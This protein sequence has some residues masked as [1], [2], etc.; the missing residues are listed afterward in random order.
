MAAAEETTMPQHVLSTEGDVPQL[1]I[2]FRAVRILLEAVATV[3]VDGNDAAVETS[4]E[5]DIVAT[6]STQQPFQQATIAPPSAELSFSEEEAFGDAPMCTSDIV[7]AAVPAEDISSSTGATIASPVS[8]VDSVVSATPATASGEVAPYEADGAPHHSHDKSEAESDI[9]T[10]HNAGATRKSDF[11]VRLEKVSKTKLSGFANTALSFLP[12]TGVGHILRNQK[13]DVGRLT[14]SSNTTSLALKANG[15]DTLDMETSPII[16]HDEEEEDLI[17]FD[18]I[19]CHNTNHSTSQTPTDASSAHGTI[20]PASLVE[21]VP[22]SEAIS[23]A[24]IANITE[25]DIAYAAAAAA[26]V[27]A[28][29]VLA[30]AIV[31]ASETGTEDT[32]K[33]AK[34]GKG[35]DAPLV[36]CA[37]S[38]EYCQNCLG[39]LI[40]DSIRDRAPFPPDCC[41]LPL[42]VDA[43]SSSFDPM[44]LREFFAKKFEV[45][46]KTPT[47]NDGKFSSVPTPPT[48]DSFKSQQPKVCRSSPHHKEEKLCHLC[49]RVVAQGAVCPNCCYRCNKNREAC[50]CPWW[51]ERQFKNNK[52]AAAYQAFNPKATS[53]QPNRVQN[54]RE[55]TRPAHPFGGIFVSQNHTS[56]TGLRNHGLNCQHWEVKKMKKPGPCFN[57]NINLPAGGWYCSQC[58]YLLCENC[59][60]SRRG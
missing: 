31:S 24:D 5:T 38:H 36:K 40:E 32:A 30:S 44:I 55:H 50:K 7:D 9:Y 59:K 47:K 57:C 20:Q 23:G 4:A 29:L 13:R 16:T 34:C 26:A 17:S 22:V 53:F 49:E 60:V 12:R 54:V 56:V 18:I 42:P 10:D 39:L 48:E 6:E 25:V 45:G 19:P 11:Q 28:A 27:A 46:C 35:R 1:I 43:N 58:Q 3:P 8:S 41:N 52:Q 21:T 15:P 51:Q 14:S 37:C 2:D 33:C